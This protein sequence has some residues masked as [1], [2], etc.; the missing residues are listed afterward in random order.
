VITVF[1]DCLDRFY[2]PEDLNM[3]QKEK[4]LELSLLL[5]SKGEELP[6]PLI[7]EAKRLGIVL[8]IKPINVNK[9]EK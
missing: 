9:K 3:H 7:N 4:V 6:K 5:L 2:T 1:R 8:P